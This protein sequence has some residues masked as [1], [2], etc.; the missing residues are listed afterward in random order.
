[1][2]DDL[3]NI[4]FKGE[5]VRSFELDVVKNNVGKLF[6]ISGPKLEALFSGKAIILKRNLSFEAANKYRVAIKKAGARIDL[7]PVKPVQEQPSPDRQT[8]QPVT[9]QSAKSQGK[10]VFNIGA[11]PVNTPVRDEQS[12]SPDLP[13]ARRQSV[14][15]N[16]DQSEQVSDNGLTLAPAGTQV[17]E[18]SERKVVAPV[19]VDVST[20]SLKEQGGDLLD[21]EEKRH[22]EVLDLDLSDVSLADVGEDLLKEDEKANIPET[23]VDISSFSIAE[24]GAQLGS[25]SQKPAPIVPDTSNISLKED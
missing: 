22:Y 15:E 2:A 11:E 9:Q 1:M 3:Y 21:A 14:Q 20:L 18:D 8:Q 17:L 24:P 12:P 4:V 19:D 16:T 7:I 23:H 6:K 10:A 13:A 25:P 5:L